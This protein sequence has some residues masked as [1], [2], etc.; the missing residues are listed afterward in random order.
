[1]FYPNTFFRLPLC[2]LCFRLTSVAK[3]SL[4]ADDKPSMQEGSGAGIDFDVD[5]N[6]LKDANEKLY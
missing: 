2:C 5:D 6:M 3:L 1:V 4:K